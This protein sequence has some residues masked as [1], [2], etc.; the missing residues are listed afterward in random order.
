[1]LG[2][3]GSTDG[4]DMS[5]R[6]ALLGLLDA[7]PMTGYELDQILDETFGYP[8]TAPRSQ[9][10]PSLRQMEAEGL[11]EAEVKHTGERERREYRILEPGR[12]ELA[13]WVAEPVPY[14]G[15]RDAAHLKASMMN[16]VKLDEAEK[17]FLA[18]R[19]HF[20]QRLEIWNKRIDAIQAGT[21]P[22]LE[23]RLRDQPPD[24]Q[25]KLIAFKLC[26]YEGSAMRARTEIEWA[27]HGLVTV[28]S[29]RQATRT[30]NSI[31]VA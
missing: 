13:R 9:I 11:I 30:P 5:L 15:A 26:G 14:A 19:D 1:M 24:E 16:M 10:Y 17:L 23:A 4:M 12:A 31:D 25:A 22:L 28:A 8:W 27:E 21:S 3:N 20:R 29:L 18:H 7:A 6:H 2:H